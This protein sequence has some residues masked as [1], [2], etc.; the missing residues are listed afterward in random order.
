MGFES[1]KI[2]CGGTIREALHSLEKSGLEIVLVVDEH[3][4]APWR[5]DGRGYPAGPVIGQH[6]GLGH[7]WIDAARIHFRGARHG[8]SGGPGPDAGPQHKPDSHP[9]TPKGA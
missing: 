3:E 8:K 5:F 6:V 9:A 7:T 2:G 4:N 1:G